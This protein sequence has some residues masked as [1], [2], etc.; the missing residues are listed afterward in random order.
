VPAA[1]GECHDDPVLNRVRRVITTQ[2]RVAANALAKR[3]PERRCETRFHRYVFSYPSR[4][5]VGR[6]V[7]EGL[8]WDPQLAE[9]VKQLPRQALVCEVGSNI[10]AS[11]LTMARER[12]DVHF[13][14]FE[15]SPRFL[16]FLRKNV[17]RNGLGSRVTIEPHLVG[18]DGQEWTLRSNTSTGSVISGTYDRHIPLLSTP[19]RSVG[20]DRYFTGRPAPNLIK[21][22]TDGFE[23]K[24]IA[25]GRKILSQFHPDVFLE[26]SPSLLERVGDSGAELL[27]LLVEAGYSHA[28]IYGTDG[29]ILERAR[30]LSTPISTDSYV[31]LW[32]HGA[33]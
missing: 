9:I 10:G 13:V 31:D 30:S 19:L 24:V 12:S 15:P 4:S 14:C 17:T 20:L 33:L 18:P 21:V 6:A 22:D 8:V 2:R 32:I 1:H 3:A 29:I 23:L 26:Y 28:S 7:A 5:I 25:S 11:L 27:R 16:P